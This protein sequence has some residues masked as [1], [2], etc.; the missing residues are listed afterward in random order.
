MGGKGEGQTQKV[1]LQFDP[2]VAW[3][4]KNAYSKTDVGADSFTHFQLGAKNSDKDKYTLFY[5]QLFY[6]KR[7]TEMLS[8]ILKLN[9]CYLKIIHILHTR[10]YPKIIG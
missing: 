5:K 9:F 10:Y 3:Q 8:N 4:L 6:K 7:Q 1:K 2:V